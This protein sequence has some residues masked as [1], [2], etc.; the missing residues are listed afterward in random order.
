MLEFKKKEW[1]GATPGFLR[2]C[3]RTALIDALILLVLVIAA[4]LGLRAAMPE[5]RRAVFTPELTGGH[6]KTKNSYGLRDR[7]F[8]RARPEGE[9]RI[10]CL[11]NS[12]TYGSGVALESTYPKQLEQRLGAG[13]LVINGGGEGTSLGKALRF[14]ERD[15]YSF[16]PELVVVGFSPGL[17]ASTVQK[18]EVAGATDPPPQPAHKKL[19]PRTLMTSAHNAL[20]ASYAYVFW[21]LN[22]RRRLYSIGVLADVVTKR[23]GAVFA[24]AFDAPGVDEGEVEAGYDTVAKQLGEL[25]AT[26]AERRIGLVV[27]GIPS[28]FELSADGRDNERN[29]P[30]DRIRIHPNERL[31]EALAG[32]GVE[33]VDLLPRLRGERAAM[34][35]G[36]KPYEPLFV[37]DYSHLD[38]RGNAIAAEELHARLR[39]RH[40]Y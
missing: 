17:I 20:Y 30:L 33:F 24:Y 13:N 9:R 28:R 23:E 26:L 4:E 32:L 6:P 36:E 27:L 11:G 37:N 25:K 5:L 35:R 15:G 18:G 16:D 1:H 14:L 2:R 19:D 7:E 22:V 3:L 8:P 10:V 21:D 34:L 38:E 31:A 40:G 12:T 29:L 39:E